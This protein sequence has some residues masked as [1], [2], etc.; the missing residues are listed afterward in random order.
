MRATFAGGGTG[1]HLYPAIAIADALVER[2]KARSQP[3]DIEFLGAK[4]RL[5]AR[6]VPAAGYALRF[7]IASPLFGRSPIDRLRAVFL[8]GAGAVGAIALLLRHRPV[9][10]IASGGY[11]CFPVVT[12]ARILRTVRLLS[13]PIVLLEINAQPG[14]TNRM[15]APLVDEV[16]GAFDEVPR[17]FTGKYHATGVPIRA[18]LRQLP[19]RDAAAHRLGLDPLKRTL[20]VMGGSQGARSIN[21]AVL[22]LLSN[23]RLPD[24]WQILHLSGESDYARVS[25]AYRRLGLANVVLP[26]LADPTDAYA[27]ANIALARAGAATLAELAA[28]GLPSILVPYPHASE[29]HQRVNAQRFERAGAAAAIDDAN[30]NA[31][32]LSQTLS[33]V[34]NPPTLQRMSE[35]ALSLCKPQAIDSIIERIHALT[36]AL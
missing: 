22:E 33:T 14:L 10:L 8:N 9:L 12:A 36:G 4:D 18:S 31:D 11:V 26:F 25:T 2:G 15:L 20:L 24:G 35:A 6:I 29:D 7:V 13:S 17:E 16:W 28:V 3:V 27:C 19:N 23:K 5:E 30:L 21:D 34:L 1:G 32:A